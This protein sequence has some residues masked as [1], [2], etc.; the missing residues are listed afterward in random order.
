MLNYSMPAYNISYPKMGSHSTLHYIVSVLCWNPQCRR[1]KIAL[2]TSG[3]PSR[4][5]R[6][7]RWINWQRQS[8]WRSR[9]RWLLSWNRSRVF[10]YLLPGR[11]LN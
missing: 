8:K 6:S 11:I 5:R 4:R 7:I 3:K 9:W 2:R 10:L 1:W